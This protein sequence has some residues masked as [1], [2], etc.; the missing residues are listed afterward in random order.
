MAAIIL[1]QVFAFKIAYCTIQLISH[2]A[3][4]EREKERLGMRLGGE[5]DAGS[6]LFKFDPVLSH[7]LHSMH[8]WLRLQP[9]VLRSQSRLALPLEGFLHIQS[10][11]F[12]CIKRNWRRLG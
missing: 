5:G 8:K 2:A 3:C 9:R 10:Q 7:L 11:L 6:R 4:K 1:S 12:A